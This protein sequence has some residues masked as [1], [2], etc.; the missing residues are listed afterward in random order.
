MT[1][2]IAVLFFNEAKAVSFNDCGS[3]S[4]SYERLK[5]QSLQY[6]S[7]ITVRLIDGTNIYET[8]VPMQYWNWNQTQLAVPFK[9]FVLQGT[10]GSTG[11]AA[12]YLPITGSYLLEVLDNG[13]L[14]YSCSNPVS[15]ANNL[16]LRNL[17]C[18]N[19]IDY[20][21]RVYANLGDPYIKQ[22]Y[23]KIR[24]EFYLPGTYNPSNPPAPLGYLDMLNNLPGGTDSW[25]FSSAIGPAG[26][27][28][29]L[30]ITGTYDVGIRT[31]GWDGSELLEPLILCE[32]IAF[33]NK[34]GIADCRLDLTL[35]DPTYTPIASLAT[36]RYRAHEIY[37]YEYDPLNPMPPTQA[38]PPTQSN[39]VGYQNGF[40]NYGRT[41]YDA[42]GTLTN[43]ILDV[44]KQYYVHVRFSSDGLGEWSDFGP[45]C[46]IGFN[47]CTLFN[48]TDS[49][50]DESCQ[51][52]LGEIWLS[53]NGGTAPFT[54]NWSNTTLSGANVTGLTAGTYTVTVTD[55]NGCV[56]IKTLA[57]GNTSNNAASIQ[58][59]FQVS[60]TVNASAAATIEWSNGIDPPI[61]NMHTISV[62][63]DGA[64]WTVIVSDPSCADDTLC[65][66]VP[67]LSTWNGTCTPSSMMRQE[68]TSSASVLSQTV[69]FSTIE[70]Y[71][72]PS[73]GDY[74][75][76][77]EG[78]AY[79]NV[80]VRNMLGKEIKQFQL[81]TEKTKQQFMLNLNDYPNGVYLVTAI[82]RETNKTIK[83]I[84]Q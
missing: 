24:Y 55:S 51:G 30:D 41:L 2:V 57:V 43:N 56:K 19:T 28:Q 81:N 58:S 20:H 23:G 45:N 13:A 67:D 16:T 54:Y 26:P 1:L 40:G 3:Q 27:N 59:S 35:A 14:L 7:T 60:L 21:A 70:V 38:V 74:N 33:T 17:L 18:T 83:I 9:N 11:T 73:E 75:I 84:K 80:V 76:L 5:L 63:A 4:L 25:F 82:G 64:T 6:S 46:I 29:Y 71:P 47:N 61:N 68:S 42:S 22:H 65:F 36:T 77:V 49:I 39:F 79:T 48:V 50:I 44:N 32:D 15:F 69:S 72:N 66:N 12:V 52:T 78:E 37:Y 62:P 10:G 31:Y 34:L 53:P 8:A